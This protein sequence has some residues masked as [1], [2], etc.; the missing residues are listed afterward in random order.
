MTNRQVAMRE[1]LRRLAVGH[2]L[3]VYDLEALHD[4]LDMTSPA[5]PAQCDECGLVI[6]PGDDCITWYREDEDGNH[7][8]VS[9]EHRQCYENNLA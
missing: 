3:T 8:A 7:Q 6:A 5:L 4:L 1:R 2:I 9:Y